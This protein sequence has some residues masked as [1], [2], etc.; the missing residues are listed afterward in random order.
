[1]LVE[2]VRTD[3][4]PKLADVR[5]SA[6]RKHQPDVPPDEHMQDFLE[7]LST[8][9][10]RFSNDESAVKV[11]E[12]E[13]CLTDEWIAEKEPPEA[14]HRINHQSFAFLVVWGARCALTQS[15]RPRL[16][17]TCV[18]SLSYLILLRFRSRRAQHLSTVKSRLL[19]ELLRSTRSDG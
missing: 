8:L 10:R 4:I 1:V 15:G 12:R 19:A 11:I 16:A 5:M 9:K 17:G 3:L 13:T 7:S 18:A 6:Q 14:Q 2:S